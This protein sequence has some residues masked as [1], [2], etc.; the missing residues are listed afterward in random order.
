MQKPGAGF[1]CLVDRD[2]RP[3]LPN[4]HGLVAVAAFHVGGGGCHAGEPA[5]GDEFEPHVFGG[6]ADRIPADR[7]GFD[8]TGRR[9]GGVD[10]LT[11]QVV[12]VDAEHLMVVRFP[13]TADGAMPAQRV[14]VPVKVGHGG[15]VTVRLSV[16]CRTACPRVFEVRMLPTLETRV[17]LGQPGVAAVLNT[18]PPFRV[19]GGW[20]P[21]RMMR[22]GALDVH[23]SAHSVMVV[24]ARL[25]AS[26][27]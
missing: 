20:L 6:P 17:V 24:T 22:V 5:Q 4:R 3:R 9:A 21:F 27:Q 23:W 18:Y 12:L 26:P 15:I 7:F 14:S 1:P 8:K 10:T 16:A 13:V 25:V 19:G 11:V 2:R